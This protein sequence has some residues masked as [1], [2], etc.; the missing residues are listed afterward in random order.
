MS[1]VA[2]IAGVVG[3]LES[4]DDTSWMPQSNFNRSRNG[5]FQTATNRT[6]T[7]TQQMF[8]NELKFSAARSIRTSTIILASFN[9]IA[10][11]AT[12]LGILCDSYFRKKRND[13][14]FRFWYD[15][16]R[17]ACWAGAEEGWL[18]TNTR[19]N[20]FT[21]VPEA[22]IFPLVLSVGI[23][24]QS[25]I[26]AG[27]QSTGLD[28]LFGLGCTWLAQLMLPGALAGTLV[29]LRARC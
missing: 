26:F 22:E 15:P 12:A 14:K 4:R 19:R 5:I 28:S 16:I 18:L 8:F 21:F 9:I 11:F 1:P 13:K 7:P 29:G 20:G 2:G 24:I 3:W 25:F 10:A 27:A 6:T 17:G 23:F